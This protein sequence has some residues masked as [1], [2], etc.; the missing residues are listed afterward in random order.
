MDNLLSKIAPGSKTYILVVL[1]FIYVWGQYFIS[2]TAV[3]NSAVGLTPESLDT[4]VKF[5]GGLVGLA[6]ARNGITNAI[7]AAVSSINKPPTQ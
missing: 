5:S 3:L 1:G 4:A 6:F 2:Q 7:A